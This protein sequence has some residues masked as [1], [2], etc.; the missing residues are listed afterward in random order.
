LDIAPARGLRYATW[1]YG[2]PLL[3]WVAGVIAGASLGPRL[4]IPR[5]PAGL[6]CGLLGLAAGLA[7]LHRADARFRRQLDC[8]IVVT[9]GECPERNPGMV[10]PGG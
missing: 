8:D 1:A 6:V 7:I 2:L 10:N 3:A 4:G 5:D 9:P